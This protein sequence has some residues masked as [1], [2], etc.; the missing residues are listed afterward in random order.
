MNGGPFLPPVRRGR[1]VRFKASLAIWACLCGLTAVGCS[2]ETPGPDAAGVVRDS[3]GIRIVDP[4]GSP[5]APTRQLEVDQRGRTWVQS[6]APITEMG[7]EAL[8]V[9]SAAGFGGTEWRV[10]G[11]DGHLEEVVGL[12]RGFSPRRFRQDCMIGILE[13]DLGVQRPAR[14]CVPPGPTSQHLVLRAFA[15]RTAQP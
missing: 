5:A 12:P 11:R 2:G 4:S 9:G 10:L 7:P 14:V 8:R 15:R 1:P 6:A 13:D 3:A